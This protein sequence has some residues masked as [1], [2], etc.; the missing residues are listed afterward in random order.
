VSRGKAL[1]YRRQGQPLESQG[2]AKQFTSN[3]NA[4]EGGS[5]GLASGGADG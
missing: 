2:T 5:Q 4:S 3:G 1:V